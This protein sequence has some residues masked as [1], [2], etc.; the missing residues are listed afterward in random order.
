VA[1]AFMA[2]R[3]GYNPKGALYLQEF[4]RRKKSEDVQKMKEWM[5][6]FNL[7]MTP[8][9]KRRLEALFIGLS[10]LNPQSLEGKVSWTDT[11]HPYDLSS[12]SPA[13]LMSEKLKKAIK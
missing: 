9:E 10:T 5:E 8:S 7:S 3:A 6:F 12:A 13:V 4:L 1:G 2:N 11:K